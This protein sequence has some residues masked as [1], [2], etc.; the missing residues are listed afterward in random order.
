MT[1]KGPRG[2]T[3]ANADQLKM[4][5]IWRT[6]AWKER[7][8][9]LL[10]LYPHCEWCG[11][12]AKVINHKR[13]GYY[14]GYEL[15][16]RDEVDIICNGC[17]AKFTKKGIKTGR[18]WQECTGCNYPVFEG[19]SKCFFCGAMVKKK[20]A[21]TSSDAYGR[22]LRLM[23]R[24]PEVLVGDRWKNVWMWADEIV[25]EGFKETEA[26]PW[27]QVVTSRG[28]VGLPAFMFGLRVAPGEGQSWRSF[29]LDSELK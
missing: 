18:V 17:H 21:A 28:E 25:I 3:H 2:G 22:L 1:V 4:R 26:L 6:K 19:K 11:G 13:Q 24:C 29:S 7:K 8:R 16:K 27:P 5:Q 9:E 10:A 23:K 15:C 12:V 20:P 14:P